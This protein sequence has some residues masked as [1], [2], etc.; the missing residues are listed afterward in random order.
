MPMKNNNKQL[1]C[2]PIKKYSPED[3][4]DWTYAYADILDRIALEEAVWVL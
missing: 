4:V 3:Q 1:R 2:S